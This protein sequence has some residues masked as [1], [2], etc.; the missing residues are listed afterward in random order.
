M[1][2]RPTCRL[3]LRALFPD[4]CTTHGSAF[5]ARY[6][7]RSKPRSCVQHASD[8][9]QF[10]RRLEMGRRS[11]RAIPEYIRVRTHDRC[12]INLTWQKLYHGESRSCAR[13]CDAVIN[14]FRCG[15]HG[16]VREILCII[17]YSASRIRVYRY[18]CADRTIVIDVAPLRRLKHHANAVRQESFVTSEILGR[19]VTRVGEDGIHRGKINRSI[20]LRHE[21]IWQRIDR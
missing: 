4:R 1:S 20:G 6:Y 17:E 8:G 7:P 19:M 12:I 13:L 14:R 15:D 9:I 16:E 10:V 2:A 18:V 21:F 3:T 5:V 11:W